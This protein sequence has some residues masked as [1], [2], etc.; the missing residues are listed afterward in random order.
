MTLCLYFD[1]LTTEAT[2]DIK[3]HGE[4]SV[5]LC[6]FSC[7]SVVFLDLSFLNQF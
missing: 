2:E 3:V 4:I 5:I 7:V 6:V 1:R